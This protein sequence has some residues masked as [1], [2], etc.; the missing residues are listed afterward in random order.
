[1]LIFFRSQILDRGRNLGRLSNRTLGVLRSLAF[2]ACQVPNNYKV[3]QNLVYDVD[4]VDFASGGF[5]D[6]R[7]GNLGGQ[8]VAVKILRMAKT[9]NV[10]ELQKVRY[11]DPDL[12]LNADQI[13]AFLQGD[14]SLEKHIPS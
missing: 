7:K 5:S 3:D 9:S 4:P 14:C 11:T 8:V 10:L 6:V 2:N 13:V 12:F 1:M